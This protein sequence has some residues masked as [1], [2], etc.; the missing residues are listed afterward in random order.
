MN[1]SSIAN[2]LI[3]S[4][5]PNLIGS[6]RVSNGAVNEGDAAF[7]GSISLTTLTVASMTTGSLAPNSVLTAPGMLSP[8]LI[9]AQLTGVS[10]GSGTYQVS[11]SQTLPSTAITA[12]GTGKRVPQFITTTGLPMQVQAVEGQDL[13]HVDGLNQQGVYRV[14][15]MNGLIEGIDRPGFSGGDLL[16]I[17]TGLTATPP[18]MDTWLVKEVLEPWDTPGWCKVLVVLQGLVQYQ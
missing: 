2:S 11:L 3:V 5:T 17:P 7:T 13:Q 9:V 8:T 6:V 18:A 14:V 16:L 12:T 1:L 4:V 10:G 15:Y